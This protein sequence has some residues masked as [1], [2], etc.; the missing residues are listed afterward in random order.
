MYVHST[1]GAIGSTNHPT[2]LQDPDVARKPGTLRGWMQGLRQKFNVSTDS[3]IDFL[4]KYVPSRVTYK[5]VGN[6]QPTVFA[7]EKGRKVDDYS[8]LVRL[9]FFTLS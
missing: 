7:T 2:I 3:H 5:P 1:P 8:H 6:I 4:T 9:S